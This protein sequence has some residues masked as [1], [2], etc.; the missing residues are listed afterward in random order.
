MIIL[1]IVAGLINLYLRPEPKIIVS[2]TVYRPTNIYRTKVEPTFKNF[3]NRNKLTFDEKNLVASLKQQ[4][5]EISQ[6]QV[7]LPILGQTPKVRIDVASPSL[8]L[9][10]L[11]VDAKGRAIGSL[12]EFPNIKNLPQ[13][14]DESGIKVRT[15]Q[16][17]LSA[18]EVNFILTVVA[19]C[20][21]AQIPIASLTLP[22]LPQ[23]LDLRTTDRPYYVK[24]YMGGDALVQTG[25]FLAARKEFDISKKQPPEYLD[26]RV[27]GKIFY[28]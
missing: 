21:K 18:S 25:Q 10:G 3:K 19:L 22:K 14:I 5:P 8:V 28:K 11:I 9:Q 20:Q 17:V 23:Q 15:G 24:F 7:E 26:V 4:F 27:S 6:V 13:V 12:S 2:S 1:L 16:S